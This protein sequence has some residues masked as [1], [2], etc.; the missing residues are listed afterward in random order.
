MK[1]PI[2]LHEWYDASVSTVNTIL[3]TEKEFGY[4]IENP[5]VVDLKTKCMQNVVL[6]SLIGKLA[7]KY[8]AIS[9]DVELYLEGVNID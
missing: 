5:I 7:K 3:K 8:P 6:L 9:L 1:E 2:D 4:E